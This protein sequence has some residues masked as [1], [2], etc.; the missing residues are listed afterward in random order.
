VAHVRE[1]VVQ[2]AQLRGGQ[3]RWSVWYSHF[4]QHAASRPANQAPSAQTGQV[5]NWR[6][7][8]P[9]ANRRQGCNN[10]FMQAY[11]ELAEFI[12]TRSPR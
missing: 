1:F 6:H 8:S 9:L 12:A 5:R 10:K 4:V 3:G 2:L 7:A 11:Q